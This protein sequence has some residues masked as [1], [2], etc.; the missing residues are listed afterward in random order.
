[1]E[2]LEGELS[3]FSDDEEDF[4]DVR[5]AA[6][7]SL[8]DGISSEEA[9]A[10]P[11]LGGSRAGLLLARRPFHNWEQLVREPFLVMVVLPIAM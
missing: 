5:K 8:L 3:D 11:G 7:L 10:V 4:S 9:Q 1:M 6:I 2:E